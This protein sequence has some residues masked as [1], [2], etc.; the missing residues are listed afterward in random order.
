MRITKQNACSQIKVCRS[1]TAATLQLNRSRDDL[2]SRG[3]PASLKTVSVYVFSLLFCFLCRMEL[4]EVVVVH[5][6][7]DRHGRRAVGFIEYLDEGAAVHNRAY[8]CQDC[9][10]IF[11]NRRQRGRCD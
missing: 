1:C 9:S 11:L 6:S 8:G 7:R 5:C 3:A 10:D 4:F 2:T